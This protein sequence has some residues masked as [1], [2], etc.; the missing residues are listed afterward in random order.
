MNK[1]RK[2]LLLYPKFPENSFWNF[3]Y[4]NSLFLRPGEFGEPKGNMPPLGILC[5]APV[6]AKKYGRENIT[7]IDLNNRILYDEDI[8][9]ADD[10]YISAMLTQRVSF[11][12]IVTRARKMGKTI[13]AGGPYVSEDLPG[14][15][16]IFINEA[17][18]NFEKFLDDFFQGKADRIYKSDRKPTPEEFLMPDYSYINIHNYTTMAVQFSRGCPHDCDFCDITQ[19]FGRKMRTKNIDNVMAELDQLYDLGWRL[20]VMFIDD[21]FIGKPSEALELLDELIPWQKARNYPFEFFTQASVLLAEKQYEGL[22]KSL[23]PAGFSMIF[24]GIETPNENSLRESNK[25][26]NLKPGLT[27][28]EKIRRIQE[29]GQLMILGG[30]IVGFDS[31]THGIFE[32]QIDFIKDIKLPNPMITLLNPLPDTKLRK[33]LV[34]ENRLHDGVLGDVAGATEVAYIPLKMTASELIMGYRKV[35]ESV[36]LKMDEFYRRC[37]NSLKHIAVKQGSLPVNLEGVKSLVCIIIEQGI[38]SDYR[39]SFWRYFIRNAF[40]YPNKLEYILRWSAYG[41]HY[42]RL[43]RKLVAGEANLEYC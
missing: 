41:L 22:L 40:L 33:R 39:R 42:N 5:L 37:E 34:L 9:A 23:A 13:I 10:I 17:D 6:M 16:H 26:H 38:K 2:A 28:P 30:F 27:L 19:R 3:R 36:Y 1:N 18:L 31:D 29:I 7:I 15:D 35:L 20:Q 25:M 11:Q 14:L 21:N 24:L 8:A 43:A 32:E 12:E 4:I